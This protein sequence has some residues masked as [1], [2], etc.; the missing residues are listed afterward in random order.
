MWRNS[1]R[2]VVQAPTS[3]VAGKSAR[4]LRNCTERAAVVTRARRLPE[5]P[6]RGPVWRP[7]GL[8]HGRSG[9][10]SGGGWLSCGGHTEVTAAASAAL[11]VVQRPRASGGAAVQP[12]RS[13]GCSSCATRTTLTQTS[14]VYKYAALS[15]WCKHF[16]QLPYSNVCTYASSPTFLHPLTDN[17]VRCIFLLYPVCKPSA[18]STRGATCC[19]AQGC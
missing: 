14:D 5:G 10:G 19:T 8:A 7:V 16:I 3:P 15:L 17:N 11:S 12:L 1:Q 13:C 18:S 4:R 9:A 2:M 6:R